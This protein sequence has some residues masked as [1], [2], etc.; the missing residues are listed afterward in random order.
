MCKNAKILDIRG[1]L[2]QLEKDSKKKI[3]YAVAEIIPLGYHEKVS[4]IL[5]CDPE[6]ALL[7]LKQM[8]MVLRYHVRL[9]LLLQQFQNSS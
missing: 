2:E 1:I 3:A 7:V 4:P 9:I 8:Q 5:N 6:T